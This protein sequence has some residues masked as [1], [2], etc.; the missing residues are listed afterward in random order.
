MKNFLKWTG[1]VLGVSIALIIITSLLLYFFLPLNAIKDYATAKLSEQLHREVKI[2]DVSFNIFSGIKLNGLTI[3]NRK[4]FDDRPFISADAIELRYAF[5]PLFKGQIIIPQITLVKPE[6]LIERSRRNDF[7][8]SDLLGKAEA[9]A[10][11]P[12]AEAPKKAEPINLII[13]TFSL[14]KGRITYMDYS[15]GGKNELKDIN[16]R[17]SGITLSLLKPIEVKASAV[18]TYQNK[19]IPL[20]LAGSLGIDPL[21]ETVKIPNLS[22]SVAGENLSAAI[23]VEKGPNITASLSSGKLSLDPFLAIFA[24]APPK[25]EKEKPVAGALTQT[26]KQAA[27]ALPTKLTLKGNVDF[28]NIT[29]ASLKIEALKMTLGLEKRTATLD[30]PEILAYNGKLALKG[31][32]NL[33]LLTYNLGKLEI[34]GFNSTPFINDMIDSFLPQM[35][36]M[37]N[38]VEGKMDVS[39]SVKGSGVEMPQVFDNLE[40]SGVILL[41]DGRLKKLKSLAGIGEQY[42]LNILKQDMLVRGLRA[43]LTLAK[44]VLNVKKLTVQD[45]DLQVAFAGG[46]DFSKMEYVKGNR[47]T[48]KFSPT[49]TGTLPRELSVFKDEQGFASLDFELVGTLTKP[50]P[51]LRLEK[52]LEVGIGKIKVK[53]EAKKVEIETKAEAKKK[54]LEEE[55]RKKLEEEAKKKVKEILKF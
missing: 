41:A 34:K 50:F 55:A 24:A 38:K 14:A 27:S 18:G 7:N 45:T 26:L 12:K 9:K 54:E 2:K 15:S 43:E 16:L 29:L 30:I 49:V 4:G 44:K 22:V 5:W 31:M 32:V 28:K 33:P 36:D 13:D 37:K 17:I 8:F 1:I 51:N 35:L 47:L 23:N 21:K 19:D 46:L 40:A 53:I 52:P 6:I 39:L 25:K 48:L 20:A 3:S 10:E 42:N 11:K